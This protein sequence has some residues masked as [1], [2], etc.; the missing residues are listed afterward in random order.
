MLEYLYGVATA[1]A[2]KVTKANQVLFSTDKQTLSFDI[3]NGGTVTRYTVRDP[4]VV[5]KLEGKTLLIL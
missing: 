3:N 1:I 2:A 5:D 4:E